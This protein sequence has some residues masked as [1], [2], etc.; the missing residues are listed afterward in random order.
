MKRL[1]LSLAVCVSLITATITQ[2][3]ELQTR[4]GVLYPPQ[5]SI[6]IQEEFISG[7]TTSGQI[8]AY[9]FG[10]TSNT[11]IASIANRPGIFRTTTSAVSGTIGRMQLYSSTS[12]AL[13]P[14]NQHEVL[15]IVRLN[16]NDANTTVRIGSMNSTTASPPSVGIYF[17]KLDADTNWF[18][19]TN[20]AAETRTDSGVAVD[21]NFNVFKYTRNSTGVTYEINRVPVCGT[22]TADI[23]SSYVVPSTQIINSAAAEKTL[24]HDYFEMKYTGMTR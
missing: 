16:T 6:I 2:S 5:S 20:S 19:V 21:T 23:T 10:A 17:E 8:G 1:L 4:K 18:C 9:G 3:S 14:D 12:N 24:D 22:H 7:G 15:W 13:F 11:G